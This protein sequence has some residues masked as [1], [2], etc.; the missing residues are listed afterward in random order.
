[1]L[2]YLNII[3][4]SHCEF[5]FSRMQN[6]YLISLY[7]HAFTN[8]LG[9]GQQQDLA[10]HTTAISFI[11]LLSSFIPKTRLSLS[12]TPAETSIIE[13]YLL[14]ARLLPQWW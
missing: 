14:S 3:T 8:L 5:Y 12:S 10:G 4:V 6:T 7:N 2:L 9:C 13:T 1:M 11:A